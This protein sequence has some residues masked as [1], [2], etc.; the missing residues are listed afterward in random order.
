MASYPKNTAWLFEDCHPVTI[1]IFGTSFDREKKKEFEIAFHT[2]TKVEKDATMNLEKG[3]TYSITM[4]WAMMGASETN[5][6]LVKAVKSANSTAGKTV[7]MKII[8]PNPPP[9]KP[10]PTGF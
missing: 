8:D 6:A 9:P 5:K 2:D 7:N 10:K 4:S 1:D 3:E